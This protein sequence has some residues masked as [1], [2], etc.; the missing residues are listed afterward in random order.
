[1]GVKS[2]EGE[3]I[4]FCG[5]VRIGETCGSPRDRIL[6]FVT[7]TNRFSKPCKMLYLLTDG[8]FDPELAQSFKTGIHV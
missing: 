1:M 6:A 8:R 4:H 2:K 5:T 7:W 3:G